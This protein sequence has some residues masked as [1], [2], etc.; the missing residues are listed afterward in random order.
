MRKRVDAL[1]GKCGIRDRRDGNQGSCF[2]FTFPYRPDIGSAEM[3]LK[4]E[5][6]NVAISNLNLTNERSFLIQRSKLDLIT[7]RRNSSCLDSPPGELE[8]ES[9]SIDGRVNFRYNSVCR[10]SNPMNILQTNCEQQAIS[11]L[12]VDDS[13]AILKMCC[14]NLQSGGFKVTTAENGLVALKILEEKGEEFDIMLTDLQMPVMDGLECVKRFRIFEGLLL[15]TNKDLDPLLIIGMSANSDELTKKEA[16]DIGM[17]TFLSKPFYIKQ[18]QELLKT[19]CPRYR[20][21]Q[22]KMVQSKVQSPAILNA[23]SAHVKY[24]RPCEEL[25]LSHLPKLPE[26]LSPQSFHLIPSETMLSVFS[27]LPEEVFEGLLPLLP[28]DI[29]TEISVKLA[30]KSDA[31]SIS[32][33][34]TTIF[35]SMKSHR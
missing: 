30:S 18:F 19:V 33:L 21:Y 25:L 6:P 10:R 12:L 13:L 34:P 28:L 2:W 7:P 35:T 11:I 23:I 26:N 27:K 15:S 20:E 16:L 9:S 32:L 14:R 31:L 8:K 29:Q 22:D 17:D 4:D 1:N 3:A 24:S 5:S